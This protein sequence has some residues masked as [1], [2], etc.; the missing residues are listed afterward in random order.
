VQP[1]WQR[2]EWRVIAGLA[3]IAFALGYVGLRRDLA[4]PA[5]PSV[6]DLLYRDLQLFILESGALVEPVHWELNVARFLAP[7]VFF[8]TILKAVSAI[9]DEQ[10]TRFRLWRARDHVVICGLGRKG[11]LLATKFVKEFPVVVVERDPQNAAI[12]EARD[13]GII[14]IAG[15]ANDPRLLEDLHLERARHLVCVC[16]EDGTN[17]EIAVAARELLRARPRPTR[18]RTFVHVVHGDLYP[19]LREGGVGW[20]GSDVLQ[21]EFFNV[22]ESGA[23]IWLREHAVFNRPGP[24][25][26]HLV[27]VGVGNMGTQ[28]VLGAARRWVTFRPNAPERLRITLV[29]RAASRKLAWLRLRRPQLDTVADLTPVEL[30]IGSPELTSGDFLDEVTAVYVC[31]DDDARGLAAALALLQRLRAR[32]VPVV[33]RTARDA[34]LAALMRRR[35]K[36][37]PEAVEDVRVEP[38]QVLDRAC[39]PAILLGENPYERL[40]RALHRE[41]VERERAKGRSS[42]DNPSIV[43]WHEL[44]EEKKES[45]RRQADHAEVKLRAIGCSMHE[46]PPGTTPTPIQLA[47]KPDEVDILARLEHNRWNAEQVFEGWTKGDTRDVVARRHPDLDDWGRLTDDAREKDIETAR[48]L[49]ALLAEAGFEVT[50]VTTDPVL[51]LHETIARYL[52]DV[53]DFRSDNGEF[54]GRRGSATTHVRPAPWRDGLT[55]VQIRAP[56]NQDVPVDGRLTSFL[57]AENAKFVFG[58]FA[59]EEE[60]GTVVFRH[61]LLGD[62]LSRVELLTAIEAVTETADRYDDEIQRR[63]GGRLASEAAS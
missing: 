50:R 63:F 45:N 14:V 15:D 16:G 33:V 28:L 49:P 18:L 58:G 5:D 1:F 57:A 39:T 36:A 8:F 46:A 2:H 29:D 17:V 52:A 19:L 13:A 27:V 25:R 31:L 61:T 40:A 23:R 26:E 47:T 12:R 3:V 59:L 44:S 6:L 43:E 53:P 20:D 11:L 51:L 32:R 48:R 41:Y 10:F 34:G 7:A 60:S 24:T 62:F 4:E 56:T 42:K 9:L 38:F 30:E 35:G 37:D 22:F 21:L 54:I 55:V